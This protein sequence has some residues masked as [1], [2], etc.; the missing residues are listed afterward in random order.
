MISLIKNT[1][2]SLM[3]E[4]NI[5]Q[6]KITNMNGIYETYKNRDAKK[7]CYHLPVCQVVCYNMVQI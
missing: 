7:T 4:T 3:I 5:R 6:I 1:N 2:I